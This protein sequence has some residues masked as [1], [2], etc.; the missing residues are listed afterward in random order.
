[1]AIW[2]QAPR[3]AAHNIRDVLEFVTSRTRKLK[4]GG[5]RHVTTSLRSFLRFVEV[6]GVRA[7]AVQICPQT[8]QAGGQQVPKI[9]EPHEVQRFLR[10]F[11]RHTAIGQR[12]YAIALCLSELALRADEI[13][14]LTLDDFD[15]RAMT[16]QLSRT[17]QRRQRLVP[18]P[19]HVSEALA[20]YLK[21]GRPQT[22][23][24]ALFV[25]HRAPLGE[26]L[27]GRFVRRIMR[28]AF[29]R[30]GFTGTG[31][32]ILRHSW[33][34]HAHR[35]GTSLKLIADFLGHRSIDTTMRYAHVNLNELR[36][37]SLPWPRRRA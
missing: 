32:H 20:A 8:A 33:A 3:T 11:R 27:Q 26:P 22:Q 23:T 30:A 10:S 13:A 36:Q 17:K 7:Q 31:T 29:I 5:V 9:L 18:L 16:I 34:T 15:W 1:V 25:R 12:D 14:H 24:R 21:T 4:W 28:R 6:T 35:S 2:P 37:A 19:D